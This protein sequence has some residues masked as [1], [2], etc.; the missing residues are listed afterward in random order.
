MT[1][2]TQLAS[3]CDFPHPW[4]TVLRA[5]PLNTNRAWIYVVDQQDNILVEKR[6]YS[7]TPRRTDRRPDA[8]LLLAAGIPHTY[9]H[10]S[11]PT[12]LCTVHPAYAVTAVQIMLQIYCT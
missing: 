8:G 2:S 9:S 5:L 3:P 1:I 12:P 7:V 4:G 10:G 11:G 6:L